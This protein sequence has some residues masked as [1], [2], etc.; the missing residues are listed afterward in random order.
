MAGAPASKRSAS[1]GRLPLVETNCLTSDAPSQAQLTHR[2]R[3]ETPDSAVDPD[4]DRWMGSGRHDDGELRTPAKRG[5]SVTPASDISP[6][7]RCPVSGSVLDMAWRHDVHREEGEAALVSRDRWLARIPGAFARVKAVWDFCLLAT[8]AHV[9]HF[10]TAAVPIAVCYS[11]R[12]AR[13]CTDRSCR[14]GSVPTLAKRHIRQVLPE[15]PHGAETPIGQLAELLQD[16]GVGSLLSRDREQRR[17]RGSAGREGVLD[18]IDYLKPG[19]SGH[20]SSFAG[21][22][23]DLARCPNSTLTLR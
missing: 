11:S 10:Q 8:C 1:R 16:R 3:A 19:E 15:I 21:S 4:G 17:A 9:L 14:S 20:T 2:G 7:L 22:V 18:Q 12:Q 13:R 5:N 23:M 6:R